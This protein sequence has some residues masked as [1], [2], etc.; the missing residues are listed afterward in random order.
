MDRKRSAAGSPRSKIESGVV[1]MNLAI[2]NASSDTL[3]VLL[4]NKERRSLIFGG[5]TYKLRHAHR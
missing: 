2:K 1:V 3:Y 4:T 5:F